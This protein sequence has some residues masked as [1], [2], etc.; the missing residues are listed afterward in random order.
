MAE[1][2]IVEIRELIEVYLVK[3]LMI[4]SDELADVDH[5]VSMLLVL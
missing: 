1:L 4:L 2:A 5:L 3:A